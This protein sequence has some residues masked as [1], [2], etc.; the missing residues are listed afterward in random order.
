[1][2]FI[3]SSDLVDVVCSSYTLNSVGT[4]SV[5]NVTVVCRVALTLQFSSP[6]SLYFS[7]DDAQELL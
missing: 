1:M 4:F 5:F 6:K 7:F 3:T 2:S